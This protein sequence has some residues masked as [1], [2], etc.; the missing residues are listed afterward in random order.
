MSIREQIAK[1]NFEATEKVTFLAEPVE[2]EAPEGNCFVLKGKERS[3]RMLK[4][5]RA[6][7]KRAMIRNI[8]QNKH[9]LGWRGN[10]AE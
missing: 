1:G 4:S 6:R 9:Q 2:W 7:A 8:K 10:A 3:D 5:Q